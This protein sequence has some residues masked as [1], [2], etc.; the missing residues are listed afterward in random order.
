MKRAVGRAALASQFTMGA[1]F[2]QCIFIFVVGLC[3]ILAARNLPVYVI[4]GPQAVALDMLQIVTV[5]ALQFSA[6]ASLIHVCFA[7]LLAF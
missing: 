7:V 2:W 6:L 1:F 3:W 5:P 4:P